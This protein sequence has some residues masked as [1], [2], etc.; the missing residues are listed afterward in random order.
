MA[1][2]A[3]RF[4][5]SSRFS[6]CSQPQVPAKSSPARGP[7]G[8]QS[9]LESSRQGK[10]E[11]LPPA[12]EQEAVQSAVQSAAVGLGART[13]TRPVELGTA[14]P[15][16]SWLVFPWLVFQ[17]I[18]PG[19]GRTMPGCSPRSC[20]PACSFFP[21]HFPGPKRRSQDPG[22]APLGTRG[23]NGGL[24]ITTSLPFLLNIIPLQT[25]C[26]QEPCRPGREG[27]RS[28]AAAGGRRERVTKHRREHAGMEARHRVPHGKSAARHL[29]RRIQGVPAGQQL[30]SV[31]PLPISCRNRSS[32]LAP[33]TKNHPVTRQ[34]QG[35]EA[36][37]RQWAG[38]TQ[39]EGRQQGLE[40]ICTTPKTSQQQERP[41]AERPL[42]HRAQSKGWWR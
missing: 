11:L 8:R 21:N 36:T 38:R 25:F 41:T 2:A 9:R 35:A 27:E 31:F 1:T 30:L 18:A 42:T 40:E 39:P 13:Q 23:D 29:Q 10:A 16:G 12:S 7:N 15:T 33:A 34:G 3:S 19:T 14:P 32:F 24:L 4:H 37:A 17:L 26:R 22:A 28:W 5:G 6:G 20:L